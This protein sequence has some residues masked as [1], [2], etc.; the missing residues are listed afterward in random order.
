MEIN[1]ISLQRIKLPL[2][3]S[4]E[5]SFGKV[6]EKDI[7]IVKVHSGDKVGFAESVAMPFPI[8]NEETTGTVWHMLETYL[9]PKLL[10]N[11]IKEPKDFSELF[12]YIR[13]NNMAKAALE[14]AIWDL[15][16]KQKGQTLS[17]ALGGNRSEIE[18]GVSIGIENNI[19]TLLNKVAGFL[20]DGYKKIKVKIKPGWDIKPL[21]AIRKKFGEQ[22]PLMADANSCYSLD[23]LQLLKELD[24]FHLMMV[25]QPLAHDDIIDHAKL[26]DALTTP[27]C[28]DESIHSVED[29]RKAIEINACKI[30]NIKVGRVGGLFE[31]VRM[32]NLCEEN[33]IPVWCGGMLET[34]IGRAHNIAIASL[35]N[36]SIP[37]D[38]SASSRYFDKDIIL[39]EVKLS[40]AGTIIVPEQLGIGFEVNQEFIDQLT[41]NQKEFMRDKIK[42]Y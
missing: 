28:L 30:I 36:F 19:E 23:D 14:M 8:Y 33:N 35:S 16:S 29:A 10:E 39:P 41:V 27:I 7:I 1:K 26:Q 31:A 42:F 13:R 38:T 37:G 34:G 15:Y 5:T 6:T 4:F 20:E 25:E 17:T 22:I 24:Q 21:E 3:S 2:K 11:E 12:S 40:K 9:I 32:H 18:V